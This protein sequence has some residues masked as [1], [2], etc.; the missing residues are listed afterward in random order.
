[1]RIVP[2]AALA[3]LV[4][5]VA[6]C[7][8]SQTP[9]SITGKVTY[10]GAPL[11]GGTMT[12]FT[13]N[14]AYPTSIATDGSGTYSIKDVPVGSASVTIETETFNPNTERPEYGA[15]MKGGGKMPKGAPKGGEN[16]FKAERMAVEGKGGGGG[17]G[18]F[19]PAPKEELEKLYKKIPAKY[20]DKR[21]S[22]LKMDIVRGSNTKDFELTD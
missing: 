14:G 1:M 5:G 12:F 4:F 17:G 20:M 7:G 15:A 11:P 3:A 2:L 13:E 19:G 8:G 16:K 9:A 22:G 21:T 6:G 10:Q 18:G